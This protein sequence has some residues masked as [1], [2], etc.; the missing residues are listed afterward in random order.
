MKGV[1]TLLGKENITQF[2]I[3]PL[4]VKLLISFVLRKSVQSNR[5]E[6]IGL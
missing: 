3:A 4:F 5:I 6:T 1:F 2:L